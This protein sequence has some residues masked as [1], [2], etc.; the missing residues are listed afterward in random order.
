LDEEEKR[1]VKVCT[2]GFYNDMIWFKK[3]PMGISFSLLVGF[4]AVHGRV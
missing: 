1:I 4:G 2:G 3:V